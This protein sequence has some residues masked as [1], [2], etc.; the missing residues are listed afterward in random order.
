MKSPAVDGY[1]Y[2]AVYTVDTTMRERITEIR[3]ALADNYIRIIRSLAQTGRSSYQDYFIHP[4]TEWKAPQPGETLEKLTA[5]IERKKGAGDD[6]LPK[7]F[8]MA[9]IK[10]VGPDRLDL[11]QT[12]NISID[13]LRAIKAFPKVAESD[14]ALDFVNILR[15]PFK[16]FSDREFRRMNKKF[17][18]EIH[19]AD[20]GVVEEL[21]KIKSGKSPE[22]EIVDSMSR[23]A[24]REILDQY[25]KKQINKVRQLSIKYLMKF[26]DPAVP[27]KH[28]DIYP[29]LDKLTQRYENFRR[30]VL[31]A[32]AV[33]IY[34]EILKA[35]RSNQLDMAL[36]FISKYTVIF[37]G[38]P[39]TPNYQEVDSFEKKFYEII[40]ERNLWDRI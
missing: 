20:D 15:N 5:M 26:A 39:K 30:E 17:E 32:A 3:P 27:N 34:H 11:S 14:E 36:Q 2:H 35:I 13:F 4:L 33:V 29:L 37:R 10:S 40:E 19:S 9:L 25:N 24:I 38:D 1:N 23:D 16:E 18:E 12:G 6:K 28:E 8:K 22:D 31:D 21:A 7:L